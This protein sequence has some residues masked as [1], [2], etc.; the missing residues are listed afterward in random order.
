VALGRWTVRST[1]ATGASRGVS[2]W[3]MRWARVDSGILRL[4]VLRTLGTAGEAR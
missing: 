1:N 3:V 2:D 4:M